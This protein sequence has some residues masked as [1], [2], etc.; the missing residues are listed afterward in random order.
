ML[1]V[2]F[3]VNYIGISRMK[4]LAKSYIWWPR[5]NS[6]I[7]ETCHK[8]NECLPLSDKPVAG[9]GTPRLTWNGMFY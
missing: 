9:L 2:E 6:D 4:A 5:L 8:C 1:L 3:H 7:E